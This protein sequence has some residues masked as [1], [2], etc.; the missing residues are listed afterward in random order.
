MK[1]QPLETLDSLLEK[2][3]MARAARVTLFER[4]VK[5]RLSVAAV[6]ILIERARILSE[7][8]RSA[9]PTAARAYFGSTMITVDV[10]TL[11][12]VVREPCDAR[13]AARVCELIRDDARV[14][15]RVHEVAR[16]EAQRLAEG[17]VRVRPGEVR[18]RAQGTFIYLDVDVEE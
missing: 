1:P 3:P 5:E 4:E 11:A 16:R 6:E 9:S 2:K 18:V 8:K 17:P 13:A 14:T 10:A 15:K 12:D 7:G